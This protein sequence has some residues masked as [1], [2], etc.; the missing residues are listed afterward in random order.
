MVQA[1]NLSIEATFA[2]NGCE[3]DQVRGQTDPYQGWV[4]VGYRELT[5]A[6]VITATCPP[7]LVETAWHIVVSR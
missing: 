2:G 5:P 7:D 4:S 3:L 6:T 1:G